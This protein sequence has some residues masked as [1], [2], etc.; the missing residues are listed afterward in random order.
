MSKDF[1]KSSMERNGQSSTLKKFVKSA[2]LVFKALPNLLTIFVFQ[3]LSREITVA[4]P[5]SM[6]T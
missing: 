6:S 1:F 3:V 5:L 2:M 4:D